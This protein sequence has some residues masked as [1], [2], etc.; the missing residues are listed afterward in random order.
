MSRFSFSLLSPLPN[1]TDPYPR[2]ATV[3]IGGDDW[4][5]WIFSA[6]RA[7]MSVG[8]DV[9]YRWEG[10]TETPWLV[11][12]D[13]LVRD[14]EMAEYLDLPSTRAA[15]TS[16]LR[17]ARAEI[18]PPPDAADRVRVLGKARKSLFL[19]TEARVKAETAL[20]LDAVEGERFASARASARSCPAPLGSDRLHFAQIDLRDLGNLRKRPS[21]SRPVASRDGREQIDSRAWLSM[22]VPETFTSPPTSPLPN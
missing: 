19:A 11:G 22:A 10:E 5:I 12:P 9:K 18:L 17:Q 20:W 2:S 1:P 4:E 3:E 14:P 15:L 16:I 21:G 7:E 8:L 13:D 6:V